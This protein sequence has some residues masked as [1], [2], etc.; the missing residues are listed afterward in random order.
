MD[1]ICYAV[2]DENGGYWTGYNFFS[3]QIRKAK[4]FHSLKYANEVIKRFPEK[5]PVVVNVRIMEVN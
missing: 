3:S 1:D 5:N 4:L 2:K